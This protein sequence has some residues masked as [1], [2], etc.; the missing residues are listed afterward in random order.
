MF[1][2]FHFLCYAGE[3]YALSDFKSK[4]LAYWLLPRAVNNGHH[5]KHLLC[6]KG[7]SCYGVISTVLGSFN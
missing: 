6:L 4:V 1:H 7:P 5:P 3:E 2:F